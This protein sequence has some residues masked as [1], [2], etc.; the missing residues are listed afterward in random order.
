MYGNFMRKEDVL[1]YLNT[2]FGAA[3][4]EPQMPVYEGE[5]GVEYYSTI[6]VEGLFTDKQLWREMECEVITFM[7]LKEE[8]RK[9][10]EGLVT[11]N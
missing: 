7:F 6:H 9:M 3:Y 4:S 11:Q 8:T 1:N 10:L 2:N 5:D